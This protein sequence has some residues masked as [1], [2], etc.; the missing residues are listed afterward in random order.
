[1]NLQDYKKKALENPEF[2]KEY[3]RFDILFE[4]QELWLRIRLWIRSKFL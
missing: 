3:E 1:M 2:R 4:L